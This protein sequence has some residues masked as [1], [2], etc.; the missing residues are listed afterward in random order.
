M[1]IK[2]LDLLNQP[3]TNSYIDKI[4]KKNIKD[5]FFYNL[6]IGFNKKNYLVSLLNPINPKRQYTDKY[7][8]RASQSITMN[9]SFKT[10]ALKLKK[11]LNQNSH[12][13]LVVMMEFF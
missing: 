2:F 3:I 7:A 8:H 12:W 10:I 6:S 9:E 5:E 11:N 4:N 13:K 1:K